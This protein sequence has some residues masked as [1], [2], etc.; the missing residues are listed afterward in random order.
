MWSIQKQTASKTTVPRTDLLN[1]SNA[2]L[3]TSTQSVSV[4]SGLLR[5]IHGSGKTPE[6][7]GTGS[8]HAEMEDHPHRD[9]DIKARLPEG[10]PPRRTA[11]SGTRDPRRRKTLTCCAALSAS[12]ANSTDRPLSA[13]F[14]EP[15]VLR[16]RAAQ[17]GRG[18][19]SEPKAL[20]E[21]NTHSLACPFTRCVFPGG[22][23]SREGCESL[24][25]FGGDAG[26]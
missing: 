19:V 15:H 22:S 13:C 7:M 11:C 16:C 24:G 14:R 9:K 10:A 12:S 21:Q 2:R 6:Q 17:E 23:D 25:R 20:Q 4:T 18:V 8:L 3:G 5:S 1:L 26:K